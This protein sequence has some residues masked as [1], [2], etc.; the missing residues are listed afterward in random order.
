[1]RQADDSLWNPAQFFE[2]IH[3]YLC[4]SHALRAS[5]FVT[6]HQKRVLLQRIN[7][8]FVFPL[9]K[10]LLG[11]GDC[12]FCDCLF[13][14]SSPAV[15][16]RHQQDENEKSSGYEHPQKGALHFSLPPACD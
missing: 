3:F 7:H 9:G 1:M 5:H 2:R 6:V 14:F 4:D 11:L 13:C 8:L 12:D 15:D 16:F 10:Q